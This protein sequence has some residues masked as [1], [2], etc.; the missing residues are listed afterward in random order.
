MQKIE[1]SGRLMKQPTH[2]AQ[3]KG[4]GFDKVAQ[5]STIGYRISSLK[6]CMLNLTVTCD[7]RGFRNGEKQTDEQK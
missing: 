3:G 4:L 2:L 6:Y 7:T 5:L 1:I